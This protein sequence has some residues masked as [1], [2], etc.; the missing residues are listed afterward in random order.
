MGGLLNIPLPGVNDF[1]AGSA[2]GMAQVA[3]GHP[4]D[5]VK[6]RLQIEG[7]SG[8]FA[9]PIDCII[10]TVRSEGFFA[11]YKGMSSPLLGIGFVNAVLFSAYGWLKNLQSPTSDTSTLSISQIALAGAGAGA[12]NAVVASPIELFKIRLQVQY[13]SRSQPGSEARYQGTMDVARQLIRDYGIRHGLFRGFWATVVREI[14]AYAGFY[15]GFEFTKRYLASISP[16]KSNSLS[17]TQLMIAGA[18]GGASYWTCS[19]PLDVVKSIIQQTAAPSVATAQDIKEGKILSGNVITAFKTVLKKSGWRSM[20]KGYGTSVVRSLPAAGALI[21]I[22]AKFSAILSNFV[23]RQQS[24]DDEHSNLEDAYVSDNFSQQQLRKSA[25]ESSSILNK[26]KRTSNFSLFANT[27]PLNKKDS[28]ISTSSQN[29]SSP[30]MDSLKSKSDE[31]QQISLPPL[32]ISNSLSKEMMDSGFSE[33][34]QPSFNNPKSDP[35]KP[36]PKPLSE[37]A[38]RVAKAEALVASVPPPAAPM[39]DVSVDKVDPRDENTPDD[40]VRRHPDLVRLTGRHPFNCEPP[41]SALIEEGWITSPALHYV[42]NHGYVPK[43]DIDTH[44][45]TIDGLINNPKTFTMKEL[46]SLPST[47]FPVTLVCAGNRRKEQNMIKQ[48]IGFSWGPSGVSN[49]L[50]TGVLLTDLIKHCGGPKYPENDDESE[51]QHVC[52]EG[53]EMLP[54]GIY[55][56]SVTIDVALDPKSDILIAYEQN[57]KPLTPDHG[58]PVRIIIPGFIGGRMIKWLSKITISSE[59]SDS[60]Y[61]Y[62]D[63]RVLPPPVDSAETANREGWWYRPEFI[64][65]ELNINSATSSPAH[66]EKLIV[67][68]SGSEKTSYTFKGYCYTGGGRKIIRMEIS[69]D[70]GKTWKL[71]TLH[72][73]PNPEP[74]YKPGNYGKKN[75]YV[76]HRGTRYWCWQ[77]WSYEVE[78]LAELLIG[79]EKDVAN[80]KGWLKEICVRAWDAGQNVQPDRP[81]WNLMGMMNNPWF[82]VKSHITVQKSDA[83]DVSLEVCFEHP[84]LPGNGSGGWMRKGEEDSWYVSDSAAPKGP[85]EIEPAPQVEEKEETVSKWI[86]MEEVKKHDKETDCWVVVNGKVYDC[87]PFLAAHPGGPE[88]IILT[89]GTDATDEFNAIH[90]QKGHDMLKDYYIGHLQVSAAG[91]DA[92]TESKESEKQMIL[93][94]KKYQKYTLA[95]RINLSKDIRLFRF[96]LP[97]SDELDENGNRRHSGLLPGQHVFVK[98]TGETEDGK[99]SMV[100]RAYTPTSID[101]LFPSDHGYLDLL[102]KIYFPIKGHP[103]PEI[104]QGGKMSVLLERLKVGDSVDMKGPLGHI[105]YLGNGRFSISKQHIA[106]PGCK[107]LSSRITVRAERVSFLAA[108][109]GITPCW[110]VIRTSVD[111]HERAAEMKRKLVSDE[112]GEPMEKIPTPP[113]VWLLYSNRQMNDIM[114]KSELDTIA[115]ANTANVRVQYTLTGSSPKSWTGISG[116]VDENMCRSYLAP[117]SARQTIITEGTEVGDDEEWD[118]GSAVF[119][120]GPD[121]MVEGS[122]KL[123]DNLGFKHGQNLFVF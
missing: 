33:S 44:T 80:P 38:Q 87:T 7:N 2:A 111:E 55:G 97:V 58:F 24:F 119:L 9:S 120:C 26:S 57:N 30:Q 105:V 115:K 90:S 29:P 122:I 69:F 48:S 39:A 123:L 10:Q 68:V 14:P 82:R 100:I 31:L 107:K 56:T 93:D 46:M 66:D 106:I 22:A 96:K 53:V 61:H 110:Q 41:L 5:T 81:T 98:C 108:G 54:N 49:S 52:F 43:C 84:T 88:S 28:K 94:P 89:A 11:L 60:F 83:G 37:I 12:I 73:Y 70:S 95:E 20:W 118:I 75:T 99:E 45:V 74:D 36:A 113:R 91:E 18:V 17:V 42:R 19:Y 102:I 103:T 79:G 50:W 32:Q 121:P 101:S 112:N 92:K 78:D 86:S 4:L 114:L 27:P 3:V 62:H 8:R 25:S 104:A 35:P 13:N 72:P 47:S 63:N 51:P 77:F 6:V 16:T 64:I 65:N 21:F 15:G 67:P 109:T 116:R 59:P 85:K 23:T 117:A 76:R 1:V 40:W 71:T 34:P